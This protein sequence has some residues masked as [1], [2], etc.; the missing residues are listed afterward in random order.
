MDDPMRRGFEPCRP[1]DHF[2]ALR[3][4]SGGTL[5]G[6]IRRFGGEEAV[7]FVS[8]DELR[9]VMF[10]HDAQRALIEPMLEQLARGVPFAVGKRGA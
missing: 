4:Q 2:A 9:A 1:F 10:H 7:T 5:A 3:T 8:G 6:F